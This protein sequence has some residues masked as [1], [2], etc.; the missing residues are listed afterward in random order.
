MGL[1]LIAGGV[2]RG[3]LDR[4]HQPTLCWFPSGWCDF[5]PC[6]TEWQVRHRDRATFQAQALSLLRTRRTS[7]KTSMK[8]LVQQRWTSRS[9][10]RHALT[11]RELHSLETL[12]CLAQRFGV[13]GVTCVPNAAREGKNSQANP[14][15]VHIAKVLGDESDKERPG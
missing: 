11:S 9:E 7:M 4:Y 12:C 13:G 1:A 5:S 6:D 8:T 2:C 3:T 10:T 15:D 14:S